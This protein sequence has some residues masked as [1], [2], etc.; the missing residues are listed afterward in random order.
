M[1]Y[2]RD[3]E[4]IDDMEVVY[5]DHATDKW[6]SHAISNLRWTD[7]GIEFET[8][9]ISTYALIKHEN[10]DPN[11]AAAVFLLLALMGIVGASQSGSVGK[12]H[13]DGGPCFIATAAFGNPMA[14]EVDTLRSFRDRCLLTNLLGTAFVNLYYRMS[15]PMADCIARH[16]ALG[17][18]ARKM[19]T[20]IIWSAKLILTL[21]P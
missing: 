6:V 4:D 15:P 11:R 16:P 1:P 8:T 12:R 19:L 5:Y 17:A 18:I 7:D 10:F 13:D 9:V 2:E 14:A 3:G 21:L 20:P